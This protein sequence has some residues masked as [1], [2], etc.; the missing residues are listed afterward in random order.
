MKF[1]QVRVSVGVIFCSF[2]YLLIVLDSGGDIGKFGW[3]MHQMD[4]VKWTCR[5]VLVVVWPHAV[6]GVVLFYYAGVQFPDKD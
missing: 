1:W 3:V 2:C 5:V 4:L 6:L